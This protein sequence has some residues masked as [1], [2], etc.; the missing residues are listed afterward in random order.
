MWIDKPGKLLE[1]FNVTGF[2]HEM[3]KT[4]VE[5]MGQSMIRRRLGFLTAL[6]YRDGDLPSELAQ[7]IPFNVFERANDLAQ[8]ESAACEVSFPPE[9]NN[10]LVELPRDK[11]WMFLIPE[12]VHSLHGLPPSGLVDG[13]MT[14]ENDTLIPEM[15]DLNYSHPADG[16]KNG[17]NI[18]QKLKGIFIANEI[19]TS[20]S[21]LQQTQAE[22]VSKYVLGSPFSYSPFLFAA[23][24]D[25]VLCA[26]RPITATALNV[27]DWL[28]YALMAGVNNEIDENRLPKKK[29]C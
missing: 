26:G 6:T 22:L 29:L 14:A 12:A 23:V 24:M 17:K 5:L 19:A 2:A 15:S 8:T 11:A 4:R 20:L 3:A 7:S 1:E 27:S 25:D 21:S 9:V 28:P 10:W 18:D 16:I 13:R